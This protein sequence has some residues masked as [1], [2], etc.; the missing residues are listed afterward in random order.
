MK[1]QRI[2]SKLQISLFIS[3]S[4]SWNS[5]YAKSTIWSNF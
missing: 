4:K 3:S 1:Y 5:F 2:E